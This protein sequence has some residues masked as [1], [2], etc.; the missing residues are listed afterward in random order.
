[1]DT[2][3]FPSTTFYDNG[4]V[5]CEASH[6]QGLG[7][8][9]W[10]Y[11][12]YQYNKK[13]I[14]YDYIGTVDSWEKELN[15]TDYSGEAFPDDIDKDGDGIV[16]SLVSED[17]EYD[18]WYDKDDFDEFV[19]TYVGNGKKL[20][21]TENAIIYE[22]INKLADDYEEYLT[23]KLEKLQKKGTIDL[24]YVFITEDSFTENTDSF[25]DLTEDSIDYETD[26]DEMVYTGSVDGTEC[27]TYY[28]ENGGF[29]EYNT[30][31]DGVTLLG[32]K[33]G[34]SLDDAIEL[35]E[36]FGFYEFDTYTENTYINGIGC[37]SFDINLEVDNND[38][39]TAINISWFSK[40]AG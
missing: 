7:S 11:S 32:I 12:I 24:A 28:M 6:N 25:T 13:T 26:K 10:P 34:D 17:G 15:E 1:M 39:I 35:L 16:Y 33:P 21:F 4:V 18:G 37:D 3:F 14:D 38:E 5:T 27:I 31:V 9:L 22:N 19:D 29:V 40:F 20:T 30:A 2:T 8:E 36:D 23:A